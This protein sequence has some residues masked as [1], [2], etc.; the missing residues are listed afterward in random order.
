MVVAPRSWEGWTERFAV[1]YADQNE[2]D[3]AALVAA[4]GAGTV[5]GQ[6]GV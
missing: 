3:H 6:V 4:I 5:E 1:S 2:T